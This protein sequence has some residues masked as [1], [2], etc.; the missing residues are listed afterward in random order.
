M[1]T[2]F[3]YL[4]NKRFSISNSYKSSS[5]DTSYLRYKRMT[6]YNLSHCE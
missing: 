4:Q 3:L 6:N 5:Q 2:G 1:S